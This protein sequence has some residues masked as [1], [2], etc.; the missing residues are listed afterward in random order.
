MRSDD[1]AGRDGHDALWRALCE[2]VYPMRDALGVGDARHLYHQDVPLLSDVDLE[3]DKLRAR[4]RV[5][6]E[7]DYP[8]RRWLLERIDKVTDEQARR[9]ELAWPPVDPEEIPVRLTRDAEEPSPQPAQERR[10]DRRRRGE[11]DDGNGMRHETP[12]EAVLERLIAIER[13]HAAAVAEAE[14]AVEREAAR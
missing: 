8:D 14:R 1:D 3:L 7:Q 12:Q 4:F 9:A 11:D 6:L 2:R 10:V 5:C 13:Q